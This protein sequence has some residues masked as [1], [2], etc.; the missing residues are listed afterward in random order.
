MFLR[1][2]RTEGE[3]H[4]GTRREWGLYREVEEYEVSA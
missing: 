4:G 1:R 3:A 2:Q